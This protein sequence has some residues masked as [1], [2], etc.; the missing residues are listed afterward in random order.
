MRIHTLVFC[1]VMAGF[2]ATGAQ[3]QSIDFGDD[4]SRWSNDGECDDPRFEGPGMTNTPLLD[5]DIG[6]DATDCRAAFE[7]GRLSLRGGQA[8][9]TG[10]KGQPAPAAQIV[11]G[12]N[13]GD[14]SGEWSRDGECDDRRFFG[15]GMASGFSWD[16]VGRDASDCVA[17]FQSGTVRMWDYTEARAATQCSAIQFGDDSGSYP[18][19]YECDDIRF[20][21]PG[22][23]MGMS[24]ENMGGDASDCSRLC[25]YGVVFLRDY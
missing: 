19:D 20:E 14:D 10:G 22:A 5:A 24:I 23:A 21:G 9:S 15:S 17:A 7:A 6:H 4:A 11:G 13:F 1:G 25:D 3:A 2:A 16:H 12:I 18:N 8:P